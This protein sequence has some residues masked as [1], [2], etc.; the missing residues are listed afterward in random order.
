MMDNTITYNGGRFN[1]RASVAVLIRYKEQF[2][3]E[4][5][6]DYS[7]AMISPFKAVTVGKRLLWCMAKCA[8]DMIPAPDVFYDDI[9]ND[10]DIVEA[11]TTAAEMMT[12]SLGEFVADGSE[13]AAED[14]TEANSDI[15][16]S[17]T[18]TAVRF[19]FSVDDLNEISVGFL[20][21]TMIGSGKKEESVK[22]ADAE[23]INNFKHFFGM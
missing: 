6:E 1:I 8:D 20:L 14:T 21:R 16:E 22:N 19:G 15:S 4:Y 2:G 17:L 9:G 3:C 7:E 10:I 23:D 18:S 13:S 12:D 11:I 5:T